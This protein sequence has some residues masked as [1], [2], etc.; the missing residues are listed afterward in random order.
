MPGFFERIAQGKQNGQMLA[1]WVTEGEGAGTKAL[2]IR[3]EEAYVPD[4][5]DRDFP[6]GI[7][8]ECSSFCSS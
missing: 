8:A 4:A 3:E 6:A 1:A 5:A 7:A 2:F